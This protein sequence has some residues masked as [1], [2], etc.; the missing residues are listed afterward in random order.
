MLFFYDPKENK[1]I[2]EHIALR[3]LFYLFCNLKSINFSLFSIIDFL[4]EFL[5]ISVVFSYIF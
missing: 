4:N 2:E 1:H 3:H 5:I